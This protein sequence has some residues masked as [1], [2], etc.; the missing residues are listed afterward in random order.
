[1]F[2]VFVGLVLSM[3]FGGCCNC[4]Q[5]VV[6]VWSLLL[7]LS[8]FFVGV[9]CW[10]G[11]DYE[12]WWSSELLSNWCCSAVVIVIVL[13]VSCWCWCC[14]GYVCFVIFFVQLFVCVFGWLLPGYNLLIT[15]V[16]FVQEPPVNCLW[17]LSI[18]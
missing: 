14:Y 2:F 10:V 3:W 8:L 13:V 5:I 18:T 12:I 11:F 4:C 15:A 1:L 7:L 6:I 17:G 9:L 16:Y